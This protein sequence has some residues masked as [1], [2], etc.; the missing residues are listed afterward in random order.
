MDNNEQ[1]MPTVT[2]LDTP[3]ASAE[4]DSLEHDIPTANLTL[5]N[6]KHFSDNIPSLLEFISRRI[7][8]GTISIDLATPVETNLYTV[9]YSPTF[10]T[11][12]NA[13]LFK[14]YEYLSWDL[15]LWFEM[16]SMVQQQGLVEMF[17]HP[18]RITNSVLQPKIPLRWQTLR[19]TDHTFLQIG[20]NT[21]AKACLPWIM[22]INSIS[23]TIPTIL[24]QR[25]GIVIVTLTSPL[26]SVATTQS[27]TIR[28]LAKFANVC[29]G[30]PRSLPYDV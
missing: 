16:D 9:S 8:K 13:Y 19:M 17:Y 15:E 5:D 3:Y 26:R 7:P 25:H 18:F 21:S 30:G 11:A 27:V 24:T 29:M 23:G 28:V 2:T 12:I 20:R 1:S 6:S 4:I 14:F 10:T 22:P